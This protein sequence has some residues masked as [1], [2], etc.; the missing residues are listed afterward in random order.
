M[1]TSNSLAATI[2]G[3]VVGVVALTLAA[4]TADAQRLIGLPRSPPDARPARE[5][6]PVDFTGYWTSYITEDYR[7][8][9]FTPPRGDYASIVLTA[10]GRALADAWDPEHDAAVGQACLAYG[11]GNIMRMPVRLHIE[12]SD[13]NTLVIETDHGQQR[14]VLKFG[15]PQR[16]AIGERTLQ[17]ESLA[18]WE[19]RSLAV[20]TRNMRASYIRRNGVPLSENAVVTE[21]FDLRTHPD[22]AI[23]FTVTTVVDDPEI[24]Y[25]PYY[26]TSDFRKLDNGD[27]WNP[28][29]CVSEWGPQRERMN[30]PD[31]ELLLDRF[32]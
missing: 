16:Q 8:R 28:S 12:W 31:V 22:G 6:A 25:R 29:P 1:D 14:R 3:L 4:E 2:L 7:Y 19:R 20:Q 26:T 30:R 10:Q 9:M 11:V 17:G 27:D 21:F 24:L 13:D 18:R 32:E 5:A 23:W 15:R